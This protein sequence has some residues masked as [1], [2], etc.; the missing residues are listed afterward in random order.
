MQPGLYYS[1]GGNEKK[2]Y[3]LGKLGI[4]YS[5]NFSC[6]PAILLE[7]YPGGRRTSTATI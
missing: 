1:D 6:A 4:S 7:I 3:A 2:W 5:E